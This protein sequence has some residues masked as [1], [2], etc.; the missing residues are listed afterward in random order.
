[1]SYEA[2]RLWVYMYFPFLLDLFHLYL[3]HHFVVLQ[4]TLELLARTKFPLSV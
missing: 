3:I 2:S 1:M 4:S